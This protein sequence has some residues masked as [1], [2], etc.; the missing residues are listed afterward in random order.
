M[1]FVHD[2]VAVSL[3]GLRQVLLNKLGTGLACGVLLYV[4][5]GRIDV[6]VDMGRAL[7]KHLSKEAA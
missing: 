3:V 5:G 1:M 6:S 2:N 4:D 7:L